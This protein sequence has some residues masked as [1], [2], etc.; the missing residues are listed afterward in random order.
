MYPGIQ[1]T[2]KAIERHQ[3]PASP[4]Y[5]AKL[6]YTELYCELHIAH[7]YNL[8]AVSCTYVCMH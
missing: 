4:V 6:P 2:A 5:S 3:R 8:H 7:S 1:H